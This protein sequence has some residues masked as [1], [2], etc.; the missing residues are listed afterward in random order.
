[1]GIVGTGVQSQ[2][3]QQATLP[4][5]LSSRCPSP[6]RPTYKGAQTCLSSPMK[7]HPQACQE[8]RGIESSCMD[9][10]FSLVNFHPLGS[11][12]F[13]RDSSYQLISA[14]PLSCR[15]FLVSL[16]SLVFLSFIPIKRSNI[17]LNGPASSDSL[18]CCDFFYVLL[19]VNKLTCFFF[20]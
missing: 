19:L 5:P 18:P 3:G 1:M 16:H 15:T 11:L 6:Q 17:N 4:A 14:P 20:C 9:F 13:Q 10:P 2:P 12:E 7:S 8:D